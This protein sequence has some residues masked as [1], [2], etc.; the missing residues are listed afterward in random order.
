MR[1]YRVVVTAVLL[2]TPFVPSIARAANFPD[3][4]YSKLQITLQRSACFGNCPDYRVTIS[5]DGSVVFT[6]EDRPIDPVAG[7]FREFSPSSGVAVPGTHRARIDPATVRSL[8]QKF[9][10]ASFFNLKDE[11]RYNATDAPTYAISIDTG[12]GSKRVVDYL[13]PEAGMPA[14]V[15]AL[16]NAVD[17]AAGTQRWIEEKPGTR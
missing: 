14:G 17:D 13:G 1:V 8:V 16:E 11:Y 15:R 7:V 4:D 6:T 9:R 10:E 12:H 5:G 3:V 2:G